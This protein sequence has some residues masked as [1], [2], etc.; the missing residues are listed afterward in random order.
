MCVL[1]LPTPDG[2]EREGSMAQMKG[3]TTKGFQLLTTAG[4][5]WG[6]DIELGRAHRSPNVPQHLICYDMAQGKHSSS[7]SWSSKEQQSCPGLGVWPVLQ[8]TLGTA[9]GLFLKQG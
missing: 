9:M 2:Q 5:D 7:G 6:S 8:T 1:V 4:G 3:S